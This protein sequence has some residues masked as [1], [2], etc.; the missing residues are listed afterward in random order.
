MIRTGDQYR[1]SLR[2]DREVYINGTRVKDVT[3][4]PSFKPLID[5]RARIYDM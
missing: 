3:A 2:D 1:A 5:I 4:H